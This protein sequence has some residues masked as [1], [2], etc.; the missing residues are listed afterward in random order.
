M[1]DGKADK[2]I[3]WL[4]VWKKMEDVI[5]AHPDKVK[6]IGAFLMSSLPSVSHTHFLI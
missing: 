4:D 2:S 5:K 6:A 1:K 3:D